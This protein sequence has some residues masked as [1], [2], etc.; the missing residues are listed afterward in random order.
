[1]LDMKSYK[2]MLKQKY[3]ARKRKKTAKKIAK[4]I[5]NKYK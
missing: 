4:R 5:T 3:T 1:M 2:P